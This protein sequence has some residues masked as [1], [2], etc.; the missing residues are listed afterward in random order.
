VKICDGTCTDWSYDTNGCSNLCQKFIQQAKSLTPIYRNEWR[1]NETTCVHT[2]SAIFGVKTKYTRLKC[3]KHLM[4]L[5]CHS[6]LFELVTSV[7]IR[8]IS[9][10]DWL[11][12]LVRHDI[13]TDSLYFLY[14]LLPLPS[15]EDGNISVFWNVVLSIYLEYW[16]LDKVH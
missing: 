3:I 11:I 7:L 12:G 8:D 1:I 9:R 15:P 10:L 5:S 4:N 6:Q 2:T 14:L 16:P 13:W